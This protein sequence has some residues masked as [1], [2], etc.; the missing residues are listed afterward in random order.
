MDATWWHLLKSATPPADTGQI[1][2]RSLV[3]IAATAL[4]AA[5]VPAV[6]S[7]H[8]DHLRVFFP[9][10]CQTNAYKPKS[11]TVFCG[12]GGMPISKIRW[13]A[14]GAKQANGRGTASVNDCDPNC[15]AGTSTNYRAQLHLSRVRQCGDVPQFT[16]LR[17]TFLGKAPKGFKNGVRQT[18]RCADAPTR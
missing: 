5:A 12:D 14:Y 17:V 3:T 2:R 18:F 8:S 6:A 7:A 16:R 11:I 1:M 4:L 9:G 10:D 13:T 15:A